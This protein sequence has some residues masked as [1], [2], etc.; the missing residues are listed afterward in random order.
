MASSPSFAAIPK[1]GT[2]ALS[3]S[4]TNLVAPFN[5]TEIIAA[6]PAG[7]RINAVIIQAQGTTTIGMVR[8]WLYDGTIHSLIR[9]IAILPVVPSGNIPAFQSVVTFDGLSIQSGYSLLASTN[10]AESFRITALAADY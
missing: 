9:E 3:L 4:D 2:G 10:N 1:V 5:S 8:L 7:T 6:G